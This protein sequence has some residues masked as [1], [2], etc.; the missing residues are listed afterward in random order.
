MNHIYIFLL[1][2][3]FFLLFICYFYDHHPVKKLD[4]E[5]I[6][7]LKNMGL[8]EK[9]IDL[10]TKD[11]EIWY[12]NSLPTCIGYKDCKKS[13]N[14]CPGTSIESQSRAI[15]EA[16]QNGGEHKLCPLVYSG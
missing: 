2:C 13:E 6:S 10:L 14:Y 3:L 11:E 5:T 12:Y 8:Q 7:A 4:K 9:Q 15:F 16:I 1:G